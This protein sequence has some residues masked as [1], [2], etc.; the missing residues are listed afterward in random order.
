MKTL[1]NPHVDLITQKIAE[2]YQNYPFPNSQENINFYADS[3]WFKEILKFFS[4]KAPNY[5][6]SSLEKALILEVGC[7]TGPT[8]SFLANK[9]P[10]CQAYGLDISSNALKQAESLQQLYNLKNLTL[11][12]DN[13]LTMDLKKKFDVIIAIGVMHHLSNIPQGLKKLIE[14]LDDKG[15]IV[16]WLYGEYGRYHLNL[17]QKMLNILFSSV[18]DFKKKVALTKKLLLHSPPSYLNCHIDTPLQT[19]DAFQIYLYYAW[20]NESWLVDQFLNAHEQ[21]FNINKIIH[22]LRIILD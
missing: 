1:E 5:Q 19:K 20:K 8:I 3:E 14:H 10:G 7:G 21:T 13:I 9:F 6:S 18:N 4:E 15:Y 17:N 22:L 2:Q 12:E 11:I 16:L